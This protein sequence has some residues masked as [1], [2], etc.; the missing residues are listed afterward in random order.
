MLY[1]RIDENLWFL[2]EKKMLLKFE[3]GENN[4]TLLIDIAKNFDDTYRGIEFTNN[5]EGDAI[6]ANKIY[7]TR[8]GICLTEACQLKCN[9]CSF[10]SEK[11][12]ASVEL[13]DAKKFV[14]FIVKN[15][16]MHR[17]IG[18]YDNS[19]I[20]LIITG[21]G[22]PTYRFNL[23][24]ELV[25][26]INDKCTANNVEKNLNI[27]TNGIINEEQCEFLYENFD[28]I[29]LSFDGLPQIQNKNRFSETIKDSFSVLDKT[30]LY[31]D[32]KKAN[33]GIRTTIWPECYNQLSEMA[34]F[35]TNR[36]PNVVQWDV[37]P[38]IPRGR[39]LMQKEKMFVSDNF[40]DYYIDCKKDLIKRKKRDILSCSKF[41]S[42]VCGT[43]YGH[44]PWLLPN[45]RIVTCQDA[46]EEAVVIGSII[47]G[48]IE[49]HKFI[50]KFARDSKTILKECQ[51][52]FAYGLCLS[53]CPLKLINKESIEVAKME[54]QMIKKFWKR[55]IKESY[56][57]GQ[58]LD[59]QVVVIDKNENN[60]KYK[61]YRLEK[62][63]EQFGIFDKA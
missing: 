30:I 41:N 44:H 38:I 4:E 8:A 19:K 52:C 54:C 34:S 46:R 5:Y 29:L 40:A 17:M 42:I 22:E 25:L 13:D 1:E 57:Q 2:P 43:L 49:L 21:G 27:T 63:D 58:F 51:N 53:G 61:A 15:A 24:K 28:F 9:Y 26:Y 7:P 60:N 56:M 14:D 6:D 10:S 45:H 37:E 35:I 12:K 50:D 55:V 47:N 3:S 48:K 36:Y 32:S 31:F 16:I 62:Y 33:Y 59:Y 23:L 39:A 11:G 18:D 20:D